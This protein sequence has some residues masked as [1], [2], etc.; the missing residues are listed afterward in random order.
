MK[1][2][3]DFLDRP[4]IRKKSRN[5]LLAILVFLVI[6]DPFISKHPY[7]DVEKIPA[8]YAVYG[9]FSCALIVAVS[10]ILGKIWLQRGENY[11]D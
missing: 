8:F 10:K 9:F 4:D 3:V 5:I 11:Y 2:I 6:I 1:K 7:F